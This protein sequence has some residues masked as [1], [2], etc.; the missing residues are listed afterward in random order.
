MP[1]DLDQS[2]LERLFARGLISRRQFVGALGALG[3]SLG[4]IEGLLG[5]GAGALRAEAA[6]APP[7]YLV[8]IVMDAFRPD[9]M[10]L[11]PMPALAGLIR[12]G[13]SYDRAWV[14]QLESETPTGH[15]TL[16]TG[17]MPNYDGI[18]GFEWRD[19]R[20]RQEVLDGWPP[21]VLHGLMERDLRASGAASIPQAVKTANPKATVVALSS[22]KVYAADAMGGWAADYT[23]HHQRSPT[24]RSV[25]NPA[26]VPGHQPP[27][28]FFQRPGLQ[29]HLPL[30]HFSDWDYFSTMLALAAFEDFHPEVLMV[31]LPG[32]DVYGHPYGGPANPTVFR[33]VVAGLDRNIGRIVQA[34]QQAGIYDQTLFV[35]TADHGMVPNNRSVDGSITKKAVQQAGGQYLFHTGGTAADVY[36]HN[37]W[38]ARAVA[39][40]MLRVPNV[41]ASY[42]Q[43]D[44]K[45]RYEYLPAP[46]L[47]ID[48]ALDNAYQYLLSTFSGS[49]APDVVA[50]FRENTIGEFV[51]TAHGDHGG[52]NW[53]AQ[54]VPLVLS[55]PGVR[56]GLVSHFPARLVDV[57]PTVLRVLGLSATPMDGTVLA[58][59]ITA[60]T[61]GD[62]ADQNALAAPLTAHQDALITAA[63]ADLAQDV[64]LGLHPP[65]SLPLRP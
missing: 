1:R 2:E 18:I 35:V 27:A 8:L 20:T 10:T 29:M 24:N 30:R 48:P 51:K 21:G 15:A 49:D 41:G 46:G 36:L 17:S 12:A 63:T 64:T 5:H 37:W 43:V 38:H 22:E 52:L 57:A 60:A 9:Y 44:R 23:L 33:Q 39:A 54:H 14:A 11:A 7:R 40:E 32:A 58:D 65:P 25:L 47:N 28:E 59:A 61:A 6:S 56:S 4:G 19:P 45:G 16:S 31:N 55:G 26:A 3:A 42:Y 34:Y 50:P 53:G 62:I 13:V